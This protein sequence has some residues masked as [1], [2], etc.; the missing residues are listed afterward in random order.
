MCIHDRCTA[1]VQR[2][3]CPRHLVC[4][5]THRGHQTAR[6]P[7]GGFVACPLDVLTLPWWAYQR[8][9]SSL[10]TLL[11]WFGTL[12]L[13]D[14]GGECAGQRRT[15]GVRDIT[16]NREGVYVVFTPEVRPRTITLLPQNEPLV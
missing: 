2:R 9:A 16:R 5:A 11:V 4:L 3:R 12:E 15:R 8:G 1:H 14:V 7:A 13:G 10:E 6:K